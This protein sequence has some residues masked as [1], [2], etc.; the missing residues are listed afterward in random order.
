MP[1]TPPV[2]LSLLVLYLCL[3]PQPP[4]VFALCSQVLFI[5]PERLFSETFL[6]VM[7]GLPPV[8]LAVVDEAHCVSEWS[9][10]RRRNGC[11]A[12]LREGRELSLGAL[13]RKVCVEN[14]TV[15]SRDGFLRLR[16]RPTVDLNETITLVALIET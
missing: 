2:Q 12:G 9:V 10:T 11:N 3:V 15:E 14:G 16:D 4:A 6:A 13:L 1:F 7:A 8:S 5:S